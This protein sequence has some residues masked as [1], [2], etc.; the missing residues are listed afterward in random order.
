MIVRTVSPDHLEYMYLR[1]RGE[2]S[3]VIELAFQ[4]HLKQL[5]YRYQGNRADHKKGVPYNDRFLI[6]YK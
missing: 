5:F 1:N 6:W 3:N 4:R 2:F